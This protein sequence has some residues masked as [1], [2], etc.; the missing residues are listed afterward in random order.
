LPL[1][2]LIEALGTVRLRSNK[3]KE[4]N[5]SWREE[6]RQLARTAGTAYQDAAR[7]LQEALLKTAEMA[8][9]EHKNLNKVIARIGTCAT[10]L[11]PTIGQFAD[12]YLIEAKGPTSL[13]ALALACILEDARNLDA[14]TGRALLAFD[15]KAVSAPITEDLK[16]ADI[17]VFG[18][19]DQLAPWLA[20]SGITLTL[21]SGNADRG[22]A[23]GSQ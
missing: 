19:P 7:A 13:D 23:S 12:S 8:R 16:S 9:G 14:S 22:N 11:L 6:A 1:V 4:L 3:R 20:S 2:A 21:A 5:N 15:R 18:T 10:I 17:K